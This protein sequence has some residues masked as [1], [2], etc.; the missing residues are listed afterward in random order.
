VLSRLE[1]YTSLAMHPNDR[2]DALA[3]QQRQVRE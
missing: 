1:A 2:V 3:Q